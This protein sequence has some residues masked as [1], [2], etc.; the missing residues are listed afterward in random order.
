MNRQQYLENEREN[1]RKALERQ[2]LIKKL[3]S[4]S[5]EDLGRTM[6]WLTGFMNVMDCWDIFYEGVKRS[7]YFPREQERED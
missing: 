7:P 1:E 2:D 3:E 4:I 6:F 5:L